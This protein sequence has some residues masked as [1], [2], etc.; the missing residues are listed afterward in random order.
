MSFIHPWAIGLGLAALALPLL[1][2][3]LTKP[4]PTR[5]PLST[6][7][8]IHE[9]VKQ[10]RARHRLKDFLILALRCLAVLALAAAFARPLFGEKRQVDPFAE[11]TTVRVVILDVSQSMAAHAQGVRVFERARSIAQKYLKYAPDLRVDL[12][13][14]SSAGTSQFAAPTTNFS[15]V[16]ETLAQARVLPHTLN[17]NASIAAA[18][19]AFVS[20]AGKGARLELVVVSD[21]QKANWSAANFSALPQD[22]KIHLES[23]A[24]ENTPANIAILQVNPRTPLKVNEPNH[25]D[26]VVGNYSPAPTSISVSVQVGEQR[27]RL[28]GVCAAGIKTTL[29]R[30]ITF[31][32]EGWK[33][34]Q[35]T[36]T[37]ITDALR[38][39][40]SHHVAL[41]VKKKPTFLLV[42]S[43]LPH[44]RPSTSY[45][46]E[47]AL[48]PFGSAENDTIRRVLPE[49][50]S[51]QIAGSSDL[52][53][54][55]RPGLLESENVAL[56]GAL[57]R[58]GRSLLYFASHSIDAVNLKR[59]LAASGGDTALP[60]TFTPRA[61]RSHHR[62]AL[63]S[64]RQDE[65]PFA[66]F[67]DRASQA[68]ADLQLMS[69]LQSQKISSGVPEEILATYED[70]SA[71][72]IIARI[73]SA[74]MGILNMDLAES[75]LPKSSC[76]VPLLN[77]IVELLLAPS[78]TADSARSG[79]R[80]STFWPQ[81]LS[82]LK[83]LR[84]EGPDGLDNDGT[85]MESDEG[86]AWHWD[87]VGA[88]GIYKAF[89]GDLIA[90]GLAVNV[91]QDEADLQAL[92]R[93]TMSAWSPGRLSVRMLD[94]MQDRTDE[95]DTAWAWL[96]FV[97]LMCLMTE[98]I[99]LKWL[100][101]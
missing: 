85:F 35:A 27:L 32:S 45:Y 82:G 19:K 39:D 77:E 22:V 49:E 24:P 96:F 9:I 69:A 100:R 88:P 61:A 40:D 91:P 6:I 75:D 11:G 44:H 10:R 84:V 30:P 38:V 34:G 47:R 56:L 70:G 12:I 98:L 54:L 90:Y 78:Q 83:H 92:D 93:A 36:I 5:F 60:V 87:Q 99:M 71:W 23:V 18:A 57:I 17:P 72:L 95:Q 8:F 51:R 76:F 53:I 15:A 21:F 94:K 13:L 62:V 20:A 97:C 67:G 29:S 52:I 68:L 42:T 64:I 14:G 28:E 31:Q 2:H 79:E 4:K 46:V 3:V 50:L 65:P 59:I 41:Y 48:D 26:V 66:V 43:E 86:V 80:F 81:H 101:T 89:S 7:R 25:L 55:S 1:V 37:G 33:F 73:A 74:K 63:A 16:K 58:R